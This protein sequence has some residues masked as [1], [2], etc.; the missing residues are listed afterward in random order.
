MLDLIISG[1]VLAALY[2]LFIRGFFFRGVIW[3]FGNY[4]LSIF[5]ERIIPSS[6]NPVATILNHPISWSITISFFI[7][8]AAIITTRIKKE[9]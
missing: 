9:E 6:A 7:V 5:L 2:F 3:F 4:G 8:V 1:G